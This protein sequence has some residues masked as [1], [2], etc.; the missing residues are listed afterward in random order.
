MAKKKQFEFKLSWASVVMIAGF[1]LEVAAG[2]LDIQDS[3]IRNGMII[4]GVV[5][6]FA[7]MLVVRS[8]NPFSEKRESKVSREIGFDLSGHF[9]EY[10]KIMNSKQGFVKYSSWRS[11][12]LKKYNLFGADSDTK[13]KTITQD[14]RYYLK[15]SRRKAEEK[16]ENI[17]VIM[18]PAEFGIIASLYELDIAPISDEMKF[19]LIMVFTALLILLCSVEIKSG[20]KIIKFIDDFC[21]VLDIPV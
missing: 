12:L 19:G 20:N 8:E 10:S 2:V 11:D 15:E 7:S 3:Y 9:N 18:I 1:I 5:L 16:V 14:I 13:K 6:I 21:E 17:K 4:A